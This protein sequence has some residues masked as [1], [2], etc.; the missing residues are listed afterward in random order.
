MA[1]PWGTADA[2]D[3]HLYQTGRTDVLG[4]TKKFR[5]A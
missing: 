5:K 4:V 1:S 2:R 3:H